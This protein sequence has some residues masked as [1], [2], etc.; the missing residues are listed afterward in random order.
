M[1]PLP[2]LLHK[3]GQFR[4][5]LKVNARM[6]TEILKSWAEPLWDRF[7]K[8]PSDFGL[9]GGTIDQEV[10][11]YGQEFDR[12]VALFPLSEFQ[13]LKHFFFFTL[14]LEYHEVNL[15][16][17][18]QTEFA[19]RPMEEALN[20]MALWPGEAISA[21]QLLRQLKEQGFP[22]ETVIKWVSEQHL[23][24]CQAFVADGDGSYIGR[25]GEG[26]FHIFIW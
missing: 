15:L 8:L 22:R 25:C 7:L 4:R 14:F 19:A 13:G 18:R 10:T 16:H 5:D 12:G 11:L 6:E 20:E 2:R 17:G 1:I 24:E 26:Y 21:E 9:I 3:R 23:E